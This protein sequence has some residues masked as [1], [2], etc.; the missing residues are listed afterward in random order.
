MHCHDAE[1]FTHARRSVSLSSSPSAPAHAGHRPCM[2]AAYAMC[3]A[4]HGESSANSARRLGACTNTPT[5]PSSSSTDINQSKVNAGTKSLGNCCQSRKSTNGSATVK[6]NPRRTRVRRACNRAVCVIVS[7]A[8]HRSVTQGC[9]TPFASSTTPMV[10]GNPSSAERAVP[11]SV[12]P[13][14]ERT[15]SMLANC[16]RASVIRHAPPHSGHAA[17]PSA[18]GLSRCMSYPQPRH[19][20]REAIADLYASIIAVSG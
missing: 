7:S 19:K 11:C 6:I 2:T 16:S 14:T 1:H 15:T 4:F 8:S 17:H 20:S 12:D 10:R 5:Q 9:A 13:C 3:F 18:S